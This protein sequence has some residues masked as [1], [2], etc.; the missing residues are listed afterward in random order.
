M[1]QVDGRILMIYK[2]ISGV[3]ES[4]FLEYLR[5]FVNIS[6]IIFGR[7]GFFGK[8]TIFNP[9]RTVSFSKFSFFGSVR[10]RHCTRD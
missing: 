8:Y 3:F 7:I 10:V 1:M 9:N 2:N 4:G 6:P 5:L